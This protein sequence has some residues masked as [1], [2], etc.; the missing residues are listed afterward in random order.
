MIRQFVLTDLAKGH[1]IFRVE[2]HTL[3]IFVSASL[4]Q[5]LS[6]AGVTGVEYDP[7]YLASE[8]DG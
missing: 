5:R 7:V 4:Q 6:A 3:D 1:D 2:E 8:A